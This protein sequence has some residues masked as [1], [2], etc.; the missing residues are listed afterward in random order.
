MMQSFD[1]QIMLFVQDYLRFDLLTPIMK[2]FTYIGNAGAVWIVLWLVLL[3][4]KSTR[5]RGNIMILAVGVTA[6]VNNLIIKNIVARARPYDAIAT[7]ETLVPQL[8]SYSFPSGHASSSIAAAVALTMLFGKRGA[9][10]F[11]P[12]VIIAL[13]RVFVGVHYP[14]D[15]AVGAL[16]GACCAATTV[17]I[18]KVRTL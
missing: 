14:S 18:Y 8:G 9:W 10:S 6:I 2:F 5:V 3:C 7:L 11:I 17:K 16:V 15:V 1:E 12:A 4:R 13:S